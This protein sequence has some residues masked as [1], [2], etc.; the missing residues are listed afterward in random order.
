MPIIFFL[1]GAIIASFM[2]VVS[3][4]LYTGHSVFFGR[5]RCDACNAP[6]APYTLVPIIS[7]ALSSGH[8]RCCRVKISPFAPMSELLLGL[9]FAL[10]YLQLSLSW[11]L[12]VFLV[13]LSLLLGIVLYDLA[14]QILPAPLLYGF[15]AAAALFALMR[16]GLTAVFLA[17]VL[18][19]AAIALFFL[20]LHFFSK[21][22]AMGFA[23]A[24]LSFGLSLLVDSSL[25][26]SGLAFSFWIGA[27]IGI[28]ILLRHPRGSRMGIEVPFA[29]FLAAGYLLI[30]FTQWNPFVFIG[31]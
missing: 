24:P 3:V 20:S 5:S 27:I 19:S 31:A 22:R 6:L 10:A 11:A 9:L 14:H 7:F 28:T 18:S 13:C 4:R 29:P 23:D 25:S 2:G 8:S 26:L 16:D 12:I 21:G 15:V 1:L 30:F 17:S